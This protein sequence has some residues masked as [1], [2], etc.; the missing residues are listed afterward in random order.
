MRSA[1]AS[2][3]GAHVW[4]ELRTILT[5]TLHDLIAGNTKFGKK[6][7]LSIRLGKP[8]EKKLIA[9]QTRVNWTSKKQVAEVHRHTCVEF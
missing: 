6:P 5:G 3:C 2:I 7:S 8:S 1:C 4:L 9:H